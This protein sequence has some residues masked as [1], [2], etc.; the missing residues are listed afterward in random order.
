MTKRSGQ[1]LGVLAVALGAA[2]LM[3][4]PAAAGLVACPPLYISDFGAQV[5][6][7]AG[8]QSAASACQYL[9]PADAGNVAEIANVNA[10]GF[11]GFADWQDNGQTVLT[12]SAST[13]QFGSWSVSNVDFAMFDY[14]L[15]F[16]DGPGTNLTA[17]L[18]NELFAEG[19][20][21][22]PF[23]NPPFELPP[24]KFSED[25]AHLT[26]ARRVVAVPEPASLALVG[27][28]MM[29][30]GLLLRRRRRSG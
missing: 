7:L 9:T 8:T 4:K 6:N 5:E 12:D 3:T 16:K 28:G 27:T 30:L 18:L 10:A 22:T 29:G 26:V 13:G 15:V 20:W 21:T 19:V 23:F 25:V 2:L 17:F 14:I 1:G 11:F 24:G